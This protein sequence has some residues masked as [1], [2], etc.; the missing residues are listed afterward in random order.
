MAK[1]K[2]YYAC[3]SEVPNHYLRLCAIVKRLIGDKD[4]E[5]RVPLFSWGRRTLTIKD[6]NGN[7]VEHWKPK[8]VELIAFMAYIYQHG[9]QLFA[10]LPQYQ[11]VFED[12]T[13]NLRVCSKLHSSVLDFKGLQKELDNEWGAY[14]CRFCPALRKK[15]VTENALLQLAESAVETMA[16]MAT[17]TIP[18]EKT[19]L[20]E[21]KQEA[22]VASTVTGGSKR[23]SSE[24]EE[25]NIKDEG[26]PCLSG[27][28]SGVGSDCCDGY[29]ELHRQLK[30]SHFAHNFSNTWSFERNE[31]KK[32]RKGSK[33]CIKRS[34]SPLS[35]KI[36]LQKLGSDIQDSVVLKPDFEKPRAVAAVWQPWV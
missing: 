2:H 23:T 36:D 25:Q 14:K 9:H 29:G 27:R 22:S 7:Y 32:S 18:G 8:R 20:G 19:P 1:A 6:E 26:R 16:A 28:D 21:K 15:T 31:F 34:S 17:G 10:A 33:S 35:P 11:F 5:G 12:G 24:A 30:C 3:I 4:D 13:D